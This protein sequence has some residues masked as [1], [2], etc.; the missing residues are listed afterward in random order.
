VIHLDSLGLKVQLDFLY[1]FHFFLIY[2][3]HHTVPYRHPTMNLICHTLL[4]QSSATTPHCAL[5]AACDDLSLSHCTPLPTCN[6]SCRNCWSK[7]ICLF[8]PSFS[9]V[10]WDELL[11][12]VFYLFMSL[13]LAFDWFSGIDSLSL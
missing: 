4:V 7:L 3:D 11:I 8:P 12:P 2:R 9:L 13:K 5:L 10:A 1:F 6:D